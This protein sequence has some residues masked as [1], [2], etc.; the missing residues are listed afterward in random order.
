VNGVDTGLT[1]TTN[2]SG[3]YAINYAPTVGQTVLV[4]LDSNGGNQGTTVTVSDGSSLGGLNLYQN[5]VVTRHDNGGALS[6]ALLNTADHG[7]TDIQYNVAAG[8]LTATASHELYIPTGHSFTPGGDVTTPSMESLGTFNGGAGAIDINGSLL[9]GGGSFTATSGTLSVSGNYNLSAGTFSH[10]NGTVVLDGANQAINGSTTFNNLTK[11]EATNDATDAIL[12]FDNLGAQT[13]SGLLTLTGL[14]S[15][16]HLNLVSDS[17]GNQ[18]NINLTGTQSIDFV[19]VTDS[20]ASGSIAG[21]KPVAPTNAIDSGNTIDWFAPAGNAA[22]S[23]V[24]E[25]TPNTAGS[26]STAHP[27]TFHLLPTIGG[28]DTGFNQTT[29][30]MPAGYANFNI[31]SIAVSS[32]PLTAGV[33]CPVVN[34]GEYCST[35]A[36]QDIILDFGSAITTTLAALTVDFTTD[37]PVA[38]GTTTL[39]YSIDDTTTGAPTAQAGIAGNA[40]GNA[41]NSNSLAIT[42]V[43]VDASLSTVT[44]SPEIII[45]DGSSSG[46]VTVKL[47]NSNG[48]PV[49]GKSVTISSDRGIIDTIVQP[50]GVTDINGIAQG[51]ISSLTPGVTTLTAVNTT[52]SI[53]LQSA[54]QAYF[55]QGQVLT[56]TKTSNKNDVVVG[57]LITYTIEIKNSTNRA[58][59]QVRLE[60]IIPDNFK[61]RTGSTLF[62]NTPVSDPVGNRTLTFNVGTVP[63]LVDTNSNGEADPGEIGYASYNYQLIVGSGATPGNYTNTVVAKDVCAL[64][65]ISNSAAADVAVILDPLFD[66]GTIIGKVFHDNN[67][68]GVQ[69]KNESGIAGAMVVLDE[70]TYS[71]TDSHG[72]YHFPAVAPGDRLLKINLAT[73]PSGATLSQSETQVVS[74]TPGLLAK[75]NFGAIQSLTTKE[76]GRPG[77]KGLSLSVTEVPK[78]M[79]LI[80][81]AEIQT[82]IV[83]GSQVRLPQAKARMFVNEI[84]SEVLDFSG[85]QL[86]HPA[87]FHMDVSLPE[88]ISSWSLNITTPDGKRVRDFDGDNAPPEII[89]WDGYDNNNVQLTGGN[90]YHYQL[91]VDYINGDHATSAR[92]LIGADH[93]SLIELKLSGGSF[94]TGNF[95]LSSKATQ[96]LKE[97]AKTLRKFPREKVVIEGHADSSGNNNINLNLSKKRAEAA[98]AYLIGEEGISPTRLELRWYGEDKPIASN[99][100]NEGR[101][102]NRRVEMKGLVSDVIRAERRSR[103]QS[104]TSASVNGKSVKV[105]S[106]GRFSLITTDKNILIEMSDKHGRSTHTNLTSPQFDITHPEEGMLIPFFSDENDTPNGIQLSPV[107]QLIGKTEPGSLIQ[108]GSKKIATSETGDFEHQLT[109]KHGKKSKQIA[110]HN[111][112]GFI[113]ITRLEMDVRSQTEDGKPFYLEAPIPE[114]KLNFPPKGAM[115]KEGD[116]TLSGTTSPDNIVLINDKKITI[117]PDGNFTHTLA[118]RQGD[119]PLHIK[120]IDPDGFEGTIDHTIGAGQSELF[121]MA[122]ADGK[123]SQLNTS[124]YIQGSGQKSASELYSEGRLAFYLKGKIQGKYLI[125]AALDTGHDEMGNLFND[126]DD[127]GSKALLKNLDPDHYYPVYGDNSTLVYDTQSQGK[128]YL[129]IDSKTIH[130]LVGNYQLDLS[131][132]ELAAY[133]RTL[134]GGLF[135]F[136]SLS[137][138][139]FGQHDTLIRL[140]SAQTRQSHVRDELRATGGSLYYLSQRD[141]IE[142]SEQVSLI[143]KDK[144]TGLTLSRHPQLQNS[145]Y[146]IKYLGGRLLFTRPIS[147]TEQDNNVINSALIAGNPVYI[148]VDYEYHVASFEKSASGA[149]A[150][151]AIGD[152]LSIGATY[153]NDELTGGSYELQGV[154]S[155]IRILKHSRITAEVAESTGSEGEVFTSSDGGL[156]FTPIA[157]SEQTGQATK[158]AAEIDIG[159]FAGKPNRLTAGAYIKELD[160]GFQASGN[161]SDQGKQ[162]SG[163]NVMVRV[164]EKNTLKLRHDQEQSTA[165]TIQP[166]SASA[167]QQ[168]IAQWQYKAEKW[169]LTGEYHDQQSEDTSGSQLTRN[170]LAATK[171]T[172]AIT[173][174]LEGSLRHQTTFDGIANDQSTVGL[175]YSLT[176]NLHLHGSATNGDKGDAGEARISYQSDKMKVYLTERFNDNQS[177]KTTSSILGGEYPVATIAGA[178]SGKIYSEYQW[179]NG[180]TGDRSLSLVGAQQQWKIENGLKFNLSSEYSDIN[181]QTGVTS[182][183]SIAVG[184]SYMRQGLKM[185]T[186]NELRNDRGL[187]RKRQILSSNSLEYNLNPDYIVLGKY[188]HS[189]TKNLT[190]GVDDASFDEH[191]IGLAYRPTRHDR[192][193]ALARYTRLSDMSPLNLNTTTAVTSQMDVVSIEWSFQITKKLE[194]SDKQALRLKTEKSDSYAEFETQT[195]LSIHRLNYRLPRR[196]GVGA[197]YR[198]LTQ[199]EADDMRSGWLSEITWE[200]NRHLRLGVGYNFTDFSDNE[201]SDNDYSTEGWFLRI[202]GKY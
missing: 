134:H 201:F 120:A 45:A 76:I 150:R 42:L 172:S 188:R 94:K 149:H 127:D 44:I 107:H 164:S 15:D 135:E 144:N 56:L 97:A 19:D 60:D 105:D 31:S 12:T 49:S 197:E 108:I 21:N 78:E 178:D 99:D 174:K 110:I 65:M 37:T 192:L 35:I 115:L 170:S 33:A 114:L 101:L 147:S 1:A 73:L 85:E 160:P 121:F 96:M 63:A 36:G 181:A 193:N 93:K 82:I 50:L 168:S 83:N 81:N 72:R 133:R 155:E 92:R 90:L 183:T 185:S 13:I 202:Q 195:H 109:L 151:Q 23:V 10:N 51:T 126:L 184:I 102:L 24:A 68:D 199:K 29:I 179:D 148:E 74:V 140:F 18:W 54:P 196:L 161:S 128:F 30:S 137:K 17:P 123:F 43:S 27:F 162:K 46:V 138:T 95:A 69:D 41:A 129:A 47:V 40:D 143:V 166:G 177:G 194:W 66:L 175:K 80:G 118:L 57:D 100:S 16:D 4:Y 122:F 116:Y 67:H 75:A 6:N 145:D 124:G 9:I 113:Y 22:T 58:V 146:S 156:A 158:V 182:R 89:Q 84:P 141:I 77:V 112:Q 180:D 189:V 71:I 3:N 154:D 165:T 70:G 88:E 7:D 14:D 157:N 190:T 98:H 104:A 20:D 167:S 132:N 173:Q 38:L 48:I 176:E 32:V 152:H 87:L 2:G 79:A 125:T 25:V 11:I 91:S 119:N 187:E 62:N 34:A 139:A 159:E 64:C 198:V 5:H 142:G 106:L 26:N 131:N 61:Y 200:A 191:S 8:A 55:T 186:R 171:I 130:T 103:F 52:D 86:V 111:P 169:S 163:A 39:S 117:E 153:V 59:Q 53:T 136:H 28:T